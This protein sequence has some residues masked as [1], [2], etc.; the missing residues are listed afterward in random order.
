MAGIYKICFKDNVQGGKAIEDAMAVIRL[1]DD[2]EVT[3]GPEILQTEAHKQAKEIMVRVV[4]GVHDPL[5]RDDDTA[6][7]LD[8]GSILARLVSMNDHQLTKLSH[9]LDK[10]DE[11]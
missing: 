3:S 5:N 4:T 8:E 2:D 7:V 11:A 10:V 1:V 9:M 6:P